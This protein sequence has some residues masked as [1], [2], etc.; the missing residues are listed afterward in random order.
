M[1]LRACL[2]LETSFLPHGSQLLQ[3]GHAYQLNDHTNVK[4]DACMPVLRNGAKMET[5]APQNDHAMEWNVNFLL[6]A[7]VCLA[8]SSVR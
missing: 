3:Y 6:T 2:L 8:T 1:L 4:M 5:V 7:T